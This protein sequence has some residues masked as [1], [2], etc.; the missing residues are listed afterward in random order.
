MSLSAIRRPAVLLVSAGL[1]DVRERRKIGLRRLAYK[2][3]V[4]PARLSGWELGTHIPHSLHVAHI[5]GFLGISGTEYEKF[6]NLAK[7]VHDDNLIAAEDAQSF[8]LM[9]TYEQLSDRVVEW[10][11]FDLP[12]LLR[13]PQRFDREPGPGEK[14]ACP[15]LEPL[16]RTVRQ[17]AMLDGSRRY[18]FLIGEEAVRAAS[19][20]AAADDQ[21]RHLRDVA[22]LHHVAVQIVPS[23]ANEVNPPHAFTLFEHR[24]ISMAVAFKNVH[25]T[26]YL[27]EKALLD[28]YSGTANALEHHALRKATAA[29]TLA[30]IP[31]GRAS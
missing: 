15:E 12:E 6:M 2:L 17:Q 3:S 27:T 13:L 5:L 29:D 14:P 18:L 23:T 19:N 25:C 20:E 9:W 4:S 24:R 16:E 30:D 21:I 22:S 1:R 31:W 28:R 8:S 11:P 26:A 10:A 7:H